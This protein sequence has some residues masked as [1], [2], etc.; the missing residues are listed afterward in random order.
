MIVL[1]TDVVSELMREYPHAKVDTWVRGFPRE[2]F[3][4]TS[5]T[6]AEVLYGIR[7]LPPGRR[8]RELEQGWEAFQ[9]RG[10]RRAVLFFDALAADAYSQ[11]TVGR[12]RLGRP[13]DTFDAMIA[14]IAKVHGAAV[15]TRDTA[16]FSGCDL[17]LVDPWE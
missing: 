4:V 13:M 15:A 8:R 16:G 11:L 6:V 7:L 2:E 5:I 3:A 9:A 12:R 10:F 14:A 1:D 17:E